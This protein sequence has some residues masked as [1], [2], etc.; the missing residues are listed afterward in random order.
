MTNFS[1]LVWRLLALLVA[2][3]IVG[4][5]IATRIAHPASAE[6]TP[7]AYYSAIARYFTPPKGQNSR[8]IYVDPSAKDALN[9]RAQGNM[10]NSV[11]EEIF[12]PIYVVQLDHATAADAAGNVSV[13]EALHTA[14]EK[15]KSTPDAYIIAYL[16]GHHLSAK[17]YGKTYTSQEELDKITKKANK[18]K[19]TR[20]TS[21]GVLWSWILFLGDHESA[22]DS[23][24][25]DVESGDEDL[26]TAA[27][28]SPSRATPTPNPRETIQADPPATGV[29]H[30][31]NPAVA[32]GIVIA[33]VVIFLLGGVIYYV[34]RRRKS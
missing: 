34:R 2:A 22:D 15:R 11:G 16:D 23:Q 26:P 24:D 29:Q 1:K 33:A 4:G 7:S 18:V 21:V 20:Y 17:A 30:S 28:P 8:W 31:I 27:S 9:A 32:R 19:K 13:I 14:L 6:T 10:T 5:F 12:T 25:G 3:T